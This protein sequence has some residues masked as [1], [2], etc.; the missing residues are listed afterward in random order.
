MLVNWVFEVM[1]CV[2]MFSMAVP[3]LAKFPIVHTPV[4]GSYAP[5]ADTNLNPAGNLSVMV[6]PA[7]LSGP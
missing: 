7:A 1:T 2:I 4:A 5:S 6:T 3:P